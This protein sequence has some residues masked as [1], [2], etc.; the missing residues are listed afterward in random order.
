MQ[1]NL[2]INFLLLL[3]LLKKLKPVIS[4]NMSNTI[5]P[6]AAS[7]VDELKELGYQFNSEYFRLLCMLRIP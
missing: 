2:L 6:A 3:L 5:Q 1:L 4:E 7:V